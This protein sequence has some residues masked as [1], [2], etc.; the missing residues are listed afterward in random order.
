MQETNPEARLRTFSGIPIQPRLHYSLEGRLQS[1]FVPDLLDWSKINF[2][3]SP[4]ALK[5][6]NSGNVMKI[7]KHGYTLG[8]PPTGSGVPTVFIHVFSDVMHVLIG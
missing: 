3:H 4:D 7:I 1:M 5:Q 6:L 2:D 8:S